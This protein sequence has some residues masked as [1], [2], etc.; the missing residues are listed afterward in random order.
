LKLIII[1]FIGDRLFVNMASLTFANPGFLYLLL[2]LI[3]LTVWY[4]FRHNSQ[5]PSIRVSETQRLRQMGNVSWRVKFRHSLFIIR[6][7]ALSLIIIV[8]A[9]PQSSNRLTNVTSEGIDIMLALDIS[10]SMLSRDFNPNR[11][12]AAKDVASEFIAG[13]PNDRI[14]L[15]VFSSESFTQ[16]PLT[17]DHLKLINL[18]KDVKSGMIDDGT[19]IG[20]GLAT[21]V[22]RL[23]ESDS[24]SKVIIL[25]TDGEN[26]AGSIAPLTAAEIAKTFGVRVYTIGVGTIGMAPMPVQTPFGIQYQNIKV[27]IDEGLLR[28][29]AEMTGGKYFRATDNKKLREIYHEIDRLEKS[30]VE[31][32]E[33]NKK[34]DQYFW[35][36]IAAA[37]FLALE[38][39]LRFTVLRT[40]P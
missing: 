13:R 34:Q 7:I 27:E 38:L 19:A 28:N 35:F 32:N 3:P 37:I 4:V 11:L 26:N 21:A 22:S 25:L 8:M 30:K 2:L 16:C 17:T 1:Q 36:A 5:K 14:G 29:I 31:I 10:S 24:K 12:E 20:L 9:R 33:Y 23:K 6:A 39:F 18:F 40:V 15:V